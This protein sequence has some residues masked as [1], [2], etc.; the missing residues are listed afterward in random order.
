MINGYLSAGISLFISYEAR[1]E[2]TSVRD[3]FFLF[4]TTG[5]S[6]IETRSEHALPLK[7]THCGLCL[8]VSDEEGIL[9]VEGDRG[10]SGRFRV[11]ASW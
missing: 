7:R 3:C 6:E 10:P 8:L 5:G 2:R 9:M 4:E 11:F 1:Q